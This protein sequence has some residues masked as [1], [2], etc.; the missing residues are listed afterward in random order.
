MKHDFISDELI[1]NALRE[2]IGQGDVTTRS[3]VP[4]DTVVQG[5]FIAKQ[6]G[7][8]CGLPLVERVFQILDPKV[9]IH[10]LVKDGDKVSPGMVVAEIS[11]NAASILSGERVALNFLQFLSGVATYTAQVVESVKETKLK[12]LD[13]RKTLPGMRALSKY[14]VRV[15]GGSNHR[16]DLAGGVLIKDNHIKAAG[17]ITN[18]VNAARIH[19]PF[20]LKIEVE[21]ETLQQVQEALEVGADIIMLDNMDTETMR[22]AVKIINGRAFTE[23]SGNMDRKNLLEVAA[24]GVDA[25]SIGSLTNNVLSLDVSLKLL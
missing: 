22:E 11:G 5:K 18:A 4:Q 6:Q 19:A 24:T 25:V 14:A 10:F 17:G 12:I 2:D 16:L 23:A 13:T 3:T 7:V 21:T 15:G 8:I 9:L 1:I 20:T